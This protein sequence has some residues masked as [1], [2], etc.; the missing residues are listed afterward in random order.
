MKIAIIHYDA[1]NLKSVFNA[2][3]R[4]GYDPV[5]ISN[6]KKLDTFDK[7]IIPGVGSAYECIKYLKKNKLF[8]EILNVYEKKK[9]IL[10]ICL[11]MQIFAKNLYENGISEGFNLFNGN[12]IKMKNKKFNIGWMDVKYTN[13]FKINNNNKRPNYYFCHSYYLNFIDK[14]EKTY[15][16]GYSDNE[17]KIPSIIQKR[18]YLGCQF[19]P[20]KSQKNGEDFLKFFLNDFT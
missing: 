19:H 7:I 16:F 17:L 11:G 10:G 8:D 15:C 6:Y 2:I 3:Y 9:S 4:L 12:V 13:G 18:N 14:D 5:I 20:E 1:C